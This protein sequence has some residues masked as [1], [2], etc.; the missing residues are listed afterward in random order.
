[1]Y[2]KKTVKNRR[3]RPEYARTMLKLVGR[4]LRQRYRRERSGLLEPDVRKDF[5]TCS[6]IKALRVVEKAPE[7]NV[8]S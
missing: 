3:P 5:P 1:M 6:V 7:A 2:E 8:N 4:Y